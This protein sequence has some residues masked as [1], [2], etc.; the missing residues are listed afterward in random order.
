MF[1]ATVTEDMLALTEKFMKTPVKILVKSEELTLEGITQYY[2][3][4]E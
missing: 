1:S 3:A 4:I 2:I